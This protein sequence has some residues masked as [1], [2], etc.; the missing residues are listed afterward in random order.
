M[1]SPDYLHALQSICQPIK[2]SDYPRALTPMRQLL[3]VLGDPHKAFP[4]VVVAGS[5]G[6]GTTCQHIARIL[7]GAGLNVGLYTSPHLHSFRERFVVNE[8]MIT[9]EDF[10]S[11]AQRVRAAINKTQNKYSTFE[12]ATALALCWFAQ[13]KVDIAVLEVGIGGRWDAVNAVP[14]ALAVFASI[15]PEH[16]IMLG[17]SLQSIAWRKAGIIHHGGH[18]ITTRQT[19]DVMAILQHEA[20]YKN[21]HLQRADAGPDAQPQEQAA[22]LALKAYQSLLER[23]IISRKSFQMSAQP[24]M[25]PGRL[26]QIQVAGRQVLIDGGH[27]PLAA[28]ALR[29]MIEALV[30]QRGTVRIVVGLLQDKNINSYMALLDAPRFHLVMTQAPGHRGLPAQTLLEKTRLEHA[31]F[32]IEP[33]LKQA[34]GQA[35]TATEALF[36]VAGSLR[37]AAAARE[38]FGLLSAEEST[39]AQIT[40]EIFEGDDYLAK[41]RFGES[42]E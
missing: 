27:T 12:Q 6:K 1:A 28:Q 32:E 34:L 21:A 25:L 35:E 24:S 19:A 3:N 20:D 11:G 38:Y 16:L 26:E 10:I 13:E 18:A 2:A 5:V 29:N 31:T 36:V 4:V 9:P 42:I 41:L 14:N 8:Q 17:G 37:M 7:R 40:R 30:R 23:K 15:E 22:Y 39:E 33:N